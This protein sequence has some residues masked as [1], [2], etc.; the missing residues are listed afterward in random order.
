MRA[1]IK[2]PTKTLL[3]NGAYKTLF[4]E[5]HTGELTKLFSLK[6][7]RQD[8]QQRNEEYLDR[9]RKFTTIISRTKEWAGMI[10]EDFIPIRTE[11]FLWVFFIDWQIFA[12]P[13]STFEAFRTTR[14]SFIPVSTIC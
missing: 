13:F 6:S 9:H 2:E 1:S 14:F 5:E 4:L 3:L 7:S 8:F 10:F 11:H 12:F